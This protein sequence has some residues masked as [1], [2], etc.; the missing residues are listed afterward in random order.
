MFH[1]GPLYSGRLANVAIMAYPHVAKEGKDA[2]E[3]IARD[4]EGIVIIKLKAS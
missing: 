1:K 2:L 4:S 3:F